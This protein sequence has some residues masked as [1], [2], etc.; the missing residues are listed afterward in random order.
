MRNMRL[1]HP[2]IFEKDNYLRGRTTDVKRV[3]PNFHP[4]RAS[5]QE[6]VAYGRQWIDS[7]VSLGSPT[8]R[9][10]ISAVPG[11]K[12]DVNLTAEA[13]GEM[14]AYGA[15]KGIVIN[16]ESDNPASEDPSFLVAVIEKAG[17]PY[18]RRLPDFANSMQPDG[19]ALGVGLLG[20]AVAH[21][22]D[23]RTQ[24]L[25]SRAI[26]LAYGHVRDK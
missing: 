16:L 11:V 23:R 3:W 15:K 8:V 20:K 13:L 26:K 10:H 24:T 9:Q 6:A 1:S 4:D 14:A 17:T 19:N 2:E 12:A 7:A 25:T 5:R 18:P 22:A 21:V